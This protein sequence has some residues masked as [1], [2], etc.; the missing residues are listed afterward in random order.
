MNRPGLRISLLAA[1]V[2]LGVGAGP[3]GAIDDGTD[4][5]PVDASEVVEDELLYLRRPVIVFA[6]SPHD[7]NFVRQMELLPRVY[8]E[9]IARDVILI[10]DTAPKERS[11]LRMRLR[12]RGFSI[13]LMDKDWGAPVRKPL[14]R[15]GREIINAIDK[16]PIARSEARERSP[17]GR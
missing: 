6:D 3:A 17:A 8:D 2:A 10:T 13:V 14:P 11:A 9:F 12:P 16:M 15:E 4:F 5:G 7:P 1:L